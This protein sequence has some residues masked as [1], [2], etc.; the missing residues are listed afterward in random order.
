VVSTA[1]D[2][3]I[4][5]I[6]KERFD[7]NIRVGY[8]KTEMVDSVDD[9]QHELV[10]EA[11]RIVGITNS[12]EISTMADIPSEGSGL[13][14]SSSV[15]VALLHALHT[16]KGELV[17]AEQLAQEACQIE[18]EILQKPN[19][20]QD[21]YIVA[22]GGIRYFEFL[23]DETVTTRRLFLPGDRW[24]R[25]SEF[26]MLFF[27]GVTRQASTILLEQTQNIEGKTD[28]LLTM[29]EQTKEMV[30]IFEDGSNLAKAGRLLHAG[31]ELKKSLAGGISNPDIDRMYE[32]ALDAGAVGGKVAGAGGGGFLLL[33]CPPDR[34]GS[35]RQALKDYRELEFKLEKNGSRVL[36]NA[37]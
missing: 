4:Y 25:L 16:L 10:R 14:S 12:V 9:L 17:T 3:Y 31:W 28:A 33:F 20:K 11:M 7:K 35:V 24:S 37:R 26:V 27:T 34:Q 5:V 8:S 13:G 36:L 6:V 19:G 23:Q 29:K 18:I 32:T 2:K 21:Q 30:R 1:I 22:F 15:T